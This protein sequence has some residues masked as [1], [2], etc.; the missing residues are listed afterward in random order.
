[1]NPKRP[2]YFEIDNDG[3]T[4]TLKGRFGDFKFTIEIAAGD[5]PSFYIDESGNVRYTTIPR[6]APPSA[7]NDIIEFN[8]SPWNAKY[9]TEKLITAGHVSSVWIQGENGEIEKHPCRGVNQAQVAYL[10]VALF[11]EGNDS[12]TTYR[13]TLNRNNG[14]LHIIAN[15]EE[16]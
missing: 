7:G 8:E 11:I 6:S 4:R 2:Y 1:M 14:V 13:M 3:E 16:L 12:D 15:E 5:K 9:K 10:H